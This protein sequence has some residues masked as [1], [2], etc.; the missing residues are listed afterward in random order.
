M[1]E[2]K[3]ALI[4]GAGRGLSAS[5]ARLF[6]K[7]GMKVALAARNTGK[8]AGLAADTGAA[9]HAC[10]AVDPASVEALFAVVTGDFGAPN[11]VVYNASNRG[12]RGPITK[13]DPDAV[14]N[15]LMISCYGGFLVA[16]RMLKMFQR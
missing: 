6:A 2:Q 1:A 4:V 5:L 14:R 8:L 12:G 15:A 9:V 7:E 16:Q 3:T 11:I 10:D 13:L